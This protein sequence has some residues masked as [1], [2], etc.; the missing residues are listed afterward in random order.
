MILDLGKQVLSELV[1]YTKYA[2]YLDHEQRRETWDEVVDR[3]E[4]FFVK[5]YPHL[6]S[7]IKEAYGFV[8]RKEVL[9]S[10]RM[11]QFAGPAVEKNNSRAYNCSFSCITE[12]EDI[13]ELSSISLRHR[14]GILCAKQVYLPSS[15]SYME[16]K[17]NDRHI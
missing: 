14:Y 12:I 4:N 6:K 10:M 13:S 11:A 3:A 5:R 9:G 7:E 2:A 1:V 16:R 17:T 15:R 8:R